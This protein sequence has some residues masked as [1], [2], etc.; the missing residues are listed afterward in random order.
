MV[1][2][3]HTD[4]V[5]TSDRRSRGDS[6]QRPPGQEQNP[7]ISSFLRK[8]WDTACSAGGTTN[9]CAAST[10]T[11]LSSG[12]PGKNNRTEQARVSLA[13]LKG[14]RSFFPL[15]DSSAWRLPTSRLLRLDFTSL[16]AWSILLSSGTRAHKAGVFP[17]RVTRTQRPWKRSSD[18]TMKSSL[19][20]GFLSHGRT[21]TNTDPPQHVACADSFGT[22]WLS[23]TN[24]TLFSCCGLLLVRARKE[25]RAQGLAVSR[26]L[27]SRH[28]QPGALATPRA[29]IGVAMR[30]Y[31]NNHL[32]LADR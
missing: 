22:T 32:N 21:V 2:S 14:R 29:T 18:S 24:L 15:F 1:S 10:T 8:E 27:S 20:F 7:K 25:S 17:T 16:L 5:H 28:T 12:T 23:E 26:A 13:M 9:C 3:R 30:H 19:N 4:A 6:E 11:R 31:I